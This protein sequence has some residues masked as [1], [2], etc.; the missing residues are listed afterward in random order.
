MPL[1]DRQTDRQTDKLRE[2]HHLLVESY[3][4]L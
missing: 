4:Q 3:N 1:T 2:T